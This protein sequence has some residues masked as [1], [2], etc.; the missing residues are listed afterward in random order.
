MDE[1]WKSVLRDAIINA[2]N[3]ERKL[4]IQNGDVIDIMISCIIVIVEV[5]WLHRNHIHCYVW[6][7]VL[8]Y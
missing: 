3:E 7:I 1:Y 6:L 4:A 8:S 2:G 5:G